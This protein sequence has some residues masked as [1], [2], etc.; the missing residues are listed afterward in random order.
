MLSYQ[1][2]QVFE[3]YPDAMI[4]LERVQSD[5]RIRRGVIGKIDLDKYDYSPDSTS[6]VR[7]TEGTVL[8]RI[9]PRQSRDCIPLSP[10]RQAL[11]E[12]MRSLRFP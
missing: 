5:G 1:K 9:P 6:L 12:E 3:E 4:Y 8:E 2:N 7:A 10:P 11:C